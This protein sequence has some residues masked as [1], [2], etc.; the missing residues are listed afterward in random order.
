MARIRKLFVLIE[1]ISSRFQQHDT[2]FNK[3]A[4]LHADPA[5][6]GIAGL[7]DQELVTMLGLAGFVRQ[8]F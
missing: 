1:A 7:Q 5:S 4:A 6:V 8:G 2:A 3:V